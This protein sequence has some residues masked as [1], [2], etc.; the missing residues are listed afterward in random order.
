MTEDELERR[1]SRLGRETEAI[2]PSPGFSARVMDALS[3]EPSWFSVVAG[4]SR[5]FLPAALALAVAL[6]VWAVR[7]E[8]S[9][10]DALAASDETVELDVE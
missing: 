9:V 5:R 1:L 2:R 4:S 10:D 3:G 6:V 7:S 8:A